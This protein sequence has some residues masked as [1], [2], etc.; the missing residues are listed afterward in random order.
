MSIQLIWCLI[1]NSPQPVALS[2]FELLVCTAWSHHIPHNR[3]PL[4]FNA[5]ATTLYSR[6]TALHT[7]LHSHSAMWLWLAQEQKSLNVGH[8]LVDADDAAL[9]NFTDSSSCL[10][11]CW[12]LLLLLHFSVQTVHRTLDWFSLNIHISFSLHASY[13]ATVIMA[14]LD[15]LAS[16]VPDFAM[17]VPCQ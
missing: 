12:H 14:S 2:L 6:V 7:G 3:A 1:K 15:Q 17:N 11:I 16:P 9:E 4:L 5:A 13:D 8:I 10:L